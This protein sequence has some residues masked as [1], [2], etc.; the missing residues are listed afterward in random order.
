[1]LLVRGYALASREARIASTAPCVIF[2]AANVRAARL[3]ASCDNLS[4]NARELPWMDT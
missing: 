1:L 2:P 3:A 4:V